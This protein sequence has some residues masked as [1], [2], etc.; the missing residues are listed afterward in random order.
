MAR[1]IP[2]NHEQRLTACGNWDMAFLRHRRKSCW[3][4][5]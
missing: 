3:T 2:K 4:G 5:L 1:A